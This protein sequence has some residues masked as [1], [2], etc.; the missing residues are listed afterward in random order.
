[1]ITAVPSKAC[2]A[3]YRRAGS[4]LRGRMLARVLCAALLIPGLSAAAPVDDRALLEALQ[5]LQYDSRVRPDA[6]TARWAALLPQLAAQPALQIEGLMSLGL[7]QAVLSDAV[8]V[9]RSADQLAAMAESSAQ[10]VASWARVAA[11]VVRAELLRRQGPVGRADRLLS[12]AMAGLPSEVPT[13]LRQRYVA[14]LARLKETGGNFEAAVRLYQEAIALAEVSVAPVW[15]RVDVRSRLAYSLFQAGQ[16][17]RAKQVNDQALQLARAA[18]HDLALSGAYTTAGIIA[19]EVDTDVA[20][21]A[22]QAAL[23]HAQRA[24]AERDEVLATANLADLS[25]RRA[26]YREALTYSERALPVARR[27]HDVDAQ[28]VALANIGLAQIMLGRKDE[29]LR[30]ARESLALDEQTGSLASTLVTH[31]ELS[32]YLERAGF[33]ADAYAERREQRRLSELLFR[34]DQQQVVI[35]LQEAFEHDQRQRALALLETEGRVQQ[36][37]IVSRQLQQS[38]WAVGT[39]IGVLALALGTL[40]AR[41]VRAGNAQLA[42]ANAQLSELSERDAL[43]GLAN[44]RHFQ[45]A[46]RARGSLAALDGTL[47]LIDIDHFKLI[48][49][50]FGHA[51]G[52]AVLVEVARRLRAS[53]RDDDLIVRWGGEEF[54]LLVRTVQRVEVDALV[55]RLL[56]AVAALPVAHGALRVPVSASIG[57]ASFPLERAQLA[58][59]IEQAVDLVDTAMY[60]AKA[61][62]RHRAFGLRRADAGDAAA[63]MLLAR[64]LEAAWRA[65]QVELTAIIGPAAGPL[66]QAAA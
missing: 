38:L 33:L 52:D 35:E 50:R 60:L 66:M 53:L 28:S 62:G 17:D 43:T 55:E 54:L 27:L 42:R 65:G 51:A 64:D 40:L 5:A 41:R 16:I 56:Q 26:D 19:A 45:A 9:E 3:L 7:A 25:L 47:M 61:H 13:P 36:A 18:Q 11:A 23:T 48:N 1:M 12:D 37:Q 63:L 24:G 34:R 21:T 39:A 31:T 2:S 32:Q 10:P 29:G 59:T 20:Q 46:L 15:Q 14:T 6:V 22:M 58:L 4:A 8:G 49:D 44:R 30:H 57:F